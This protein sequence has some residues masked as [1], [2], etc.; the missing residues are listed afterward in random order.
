MGLKADITADLKAAFADELKD[1]IKPFTGS[2]IE[3]VTEIDTTSDA[4]LDNL[5]AQQQTLTYT[6]KGVFDGYKA[7]EIDGES[8]KLNDVKLIC[9]Q[10]NIKPQLDDLIT[11][12]DGSYQVIAVNKDP[13]N[14]TWELQLRRAGG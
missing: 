5:P 11:N 1:A 6:G 9:L 13:A 3:A 12:S 4:W 14:V 8:I 7:I 10:D 2:R